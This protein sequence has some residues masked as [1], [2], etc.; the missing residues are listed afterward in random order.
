MR[1]HRVPG[2]PTNSRPG[3]Y[4][5]ADT[6]QLQRPETR[7]MTRPKSL[8]EERSTVENAPG[9]RIGQARDQALRPGIR[10]PIE[11]TSPASIRD[12]FALMARAMHVS[13]VSLDRIRAGT[14]GLVVSVA[15]SSAD[16]LRCG[17]AWRWSGARSRQRRT[18]L[19]M[20]LSGNRGPG[21]TPPSRPR[22]AGCPWPRVCR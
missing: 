8:T 12:R 15:F 2:A 11:K 22:T 1:S 14:N 5:P 10:Q 7:G 21:P 3:R 16:D 18:S 20:R 6:S 17:C 19:A 9:N 13:N 4:D